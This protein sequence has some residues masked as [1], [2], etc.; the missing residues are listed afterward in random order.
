M[1]YWKHLIKYKS[2]VEFQEIVSRKN[3]LYFIVNYSKKSEVLKL[4]YLLQ[5]QQLSF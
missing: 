2:W 1:Y 5:K 3:I 4:I